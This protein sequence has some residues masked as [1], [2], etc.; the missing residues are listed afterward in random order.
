MQPGVVTTAV[1]ESVHGHLSKAA[2]ILSVSESALRNNVSSHHVPSPISF[3]ALNK[4]CLSA[5]GGGGASASQLYIASLDGKPVVSARLKAVERGADA[6]I[7]RKRGRDD[8]G[9]RAKAA[10]AKLTR[11]DKINK[12]QL[13]LAETTVRQLLRNL[14]GPDGEDI[15]QSCGVSISPPSSSHDGK[16]RLIIACRLSAGVPLSLKA[17]RSSLG[18]CF[19]DGMITTRAEDIS[20]EFQLPLTESGQVVEDSG[21][22]SILL[23][24]AVPEN[25]E[26]TL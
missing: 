12:N 25:V 7:K 20:A 22:K 24:A 13:E 26:T 1:A 5:T 21:Q 6:R 18:A 17:L 15:F 4:F 8:S 11:I 10:V 19:G 9:E 14:H 23:F 2:V 16:P 3:H